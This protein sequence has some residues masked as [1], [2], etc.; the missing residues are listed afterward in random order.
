[1]KS[2][3]IVV[4]VFYN[5]HSLPPLFTA[6][7]SLEAKLKEKKMDLEL[8]FVD[9]GSED[10]S[11]LELLKIRLQKP[12]VKIIK[13]S[14]NFGAVRAVKT[15]L[16][17]VTGDCFTFLAADMQDPPQLIEQMVEHW[18]NGAKYVTCVRTERDDPLGSRVFSFLF[19]KLVRFFA[20]RDFPNGGF[21]LVLMDKVILPYLL[22][23]GKNINFALYVHALGF[24]PEVI[25]YKRLK[26]VH[27]KS[28]W[29][30]AKKFNYFIDSLI[31]FSIIPIRLISG[32]GISLAIISFIYGMIVVI[33]V[34]ISGSTLPGFAALATLISFLCGL[35]LIMMGIMGEYMWRIFDQINGSPEAVVETTLLE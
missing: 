22:K 18:L 30:F 24:T 35:L 16:R 21:D 11:Y 31:G 1:M 33:S 7:L 17:F 23:S 4:P 25:Y 26:R 27:G 28:R 29:T 8:I 2:L 6:L 19:Y 32:I 9:D 14:R 3:S 10:N 20:V 12:S 5:Q 34:I 15:G 13:H